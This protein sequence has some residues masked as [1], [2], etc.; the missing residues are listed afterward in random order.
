MARRRSSEDER[1]EKIMGSSPSGSEAELREMTP[2]TI[3]CA[4]GGSPAPHLERRRTSNKRP[5]T[6]TAL[7]T[8]GAQPSLA[9]LL[10]SDLGPRSHDPEGR[11]MR[12]PRGRTE[13]L[14]IALI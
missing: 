7:G 11:S 13:E 8:W 4:T 6:T 10:W 14:R 3:W 5:G 12:I 1:D 9:T 2:E